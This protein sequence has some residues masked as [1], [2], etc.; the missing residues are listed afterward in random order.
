M[1]V[2]RR[3]ELVTATG[4]CIRRNN[5]AQCGSRVGHRTMVLDHVCRLTLAQTLTNNTNGLKKKAFTESVL[6]PRST[7]TNIYE[8]VLLN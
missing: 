6:L 1:A 8:L 3:T 2:G 4:H 5:Y 7:H